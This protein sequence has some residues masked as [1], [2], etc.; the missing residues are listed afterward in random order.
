MFR[1]KNTAR[2]SPRGG[3]GGRPIQAPMRRGG[4]TF[5]RAVGARRGRRPGGRAIKN[6]T[7]L[8]SALAGLRSRTGKR[9][10]RR[11][12]LSRSRSFSKGLFDP[13]LKSMVDKASGRGRAARGSQTRGTGMLA[14]G[15]GRAVKVGPVRAARRPQ[16]KRR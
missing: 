13:R 11:G 9:G 15:R 5:G 7:T 2:P 12:G 6:N 10:G 4:S 14:T 16:Y 1:Q 8:S 3:K